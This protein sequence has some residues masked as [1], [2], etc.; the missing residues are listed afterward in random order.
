MLAPAM[1]V[2]FPLLLSVNLQTGRV[3]AYHQVLPAVQALP[4]LHVF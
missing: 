3:Y 1:L 2:N 4:V